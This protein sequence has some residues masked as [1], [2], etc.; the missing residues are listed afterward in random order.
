MKMLRRAFSSKHSTLGL[1]AVS[2]PRCAV[3]LSVL[4]GTMGAAAQPGLNSTPRSCPDLE[5]R[6]LNAGDTIVAPEGFTH[7]FFY[8]ASAKKS[9]SE[10]SL[11]AGSWTLQRDQQIRATQFKYAN[12][13]IDV[14]L[15]WVRRDTDP[16]LYC[17]QKFNVPNP[18]VN[19]VLCGGGAVGTPCMKGLGDQLVMEI[20][21]LDAW[22][23]D[24]KA[25]RKSTSE[26]RGDLVPFFNGVPLAGI[27]PENPMV[28][29]ENVVDGEPVTALL[30]TLARNDANKAA[31]NRLLN[32]F[33][34]NGRPVNVSVG[35]ESGAEIPTVVLND[36]KVPEKERQFRHFTLAVLPHGATIAAFAVLAGALTG[37]SVLMVT[38]DIVKDPAA[39]RRPDGHR[40]F[41][42]ARMQMAFW[43]FLVASAYVLLFLTT[44]D[45]DTLTTSVLTLM[46][47]SAGTALGAA[48]IDA[49]TTTDKFRNVTT[50]RPDDP[51]ASRAELDR[52]IEDLRQE[53]AARKS[54]PATTDEERR[55]KQA[56]ESSLQDNLAVARQHRAFFG[57]PPW[58]VVM[59]DLLGDDG[60]ISFHRFQI[61]AWTLVLG[62][63]FVVRVL[64][65][66]AMPEFSGTI[67]GLMGVSSGTYVGFKLSPARESGAATKAAP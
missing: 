47:I 37:F 34:W 56:A 43:F 42:L 28:R 50:V 46:G 21:S 32:G 48:I 8:D 52:R 40:P 7:L 25:E 30:F 38:T 64:S 63:V 51:K 13:P 17:L 27:H 61:L 14:Q 62:I 5:S 36:P 10:L 24:V 4:F 53:L 44:K 3:L 11:T 67:L 65:D 29:A 45:G 12:P 9:I 19:A 57:L 15:A 22:I 41:S 39:P 49:G 1:G 58:R 26:T 18:V 54:Q 59:N 6:F 35:F 66:L 16:P 55:V 2:L 60:E 31:W 33:V 23:D 20:Y